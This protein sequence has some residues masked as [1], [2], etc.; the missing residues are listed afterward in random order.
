[1]IEKKSLNVKLYLKPMRRIEH[2]S[3][4]LSLKVF[5]EFAE[6]SDSKYCYYSKRV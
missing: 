6:F 2:I 4:E 3:I 5:I 1:M